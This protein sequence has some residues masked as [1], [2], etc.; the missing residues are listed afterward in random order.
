MNSVK[1]IQIKTQK[2]KAIKLIAVG[3]HDEAAVILK[4]LIR[5]DHSDVEILTGLAHCYSMFGQPFEALF[6]LDRALEE[7]P[8]YLH[9]KFLKGCVLGDLGKNLEGIAMIKNVIENGLVDFEMYGNLGVLYQNS[10]DYSS[11]ITAYIKALS[12]SSI[13]NP[14]VIENRLANCY[15]ELGQFSESMT[16]Y[17]KLIND[18]PKDTTAL[19][20]KAVACEKMGNTPESLKLLKQVVDIDS[21]FSK[22]WDELADLYDKINAPDEAKKCRTKAEEIRSKE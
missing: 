8:D 1:K 10:C 14:E 15:S 5:K 17:D 12:F 13:V 3:K 20:N 7:D 16:I 4:S 21:D 19:F 9:A 6:L 22:A 2:E 11:A 18:N